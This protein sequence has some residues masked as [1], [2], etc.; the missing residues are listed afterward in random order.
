MFFYNQQPNLYLGYMKTTTKTILLMSLYCLIHQQAAAQ[1]N[2]VPNPSFEDYDSC[3]YFITD[4]YAKYWK[5]PSTATPDYH[6]ANCNNS[7]S[8]VPQN[9]FGYQFARTGFAYAGFLTSDLSP[10][11]TEYRE[12]IQ[13]KL[14]QK[15]ESGK[16]YTISF[17]V[18]FADSSQKACDNIGA[19]ISNNAIS[20]I[21]NL[22]INVIPQIVS[23]HRHPIDNSIEWTE[24]SGTYNAD[25]GEEYLTIGVFSNNSNTSYIETNRGWSE[26]PYYYVDDV[27]IIL[28][29]NFPFMVP[30][31]F[32][33]NADLT[34]DTY[35]P[36]YFDNNLKVKEFRIYNCWGELVYNNPDTPWDG[37]YKGIPQPQGI[38]AFFVYVA[39]PV[40]DN[41]SKIPTYKK[42]GSFALIR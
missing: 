16:R 30:T 31:A 19:Y 9:G 6:Q 3:A 25:G 24:I 11:S 42:V 12:Y 40:P 41:L 4:F 1:I 5:S 33:P 13:C 38:Y 35:Y 22:R 18:S 23:T 7:F 32:T 27:A 20:S 28:D 14:L 17:Y 10:K 34:N 29:E 37:T 26:E 15:L 21:D 36:V 8:G 2:L 39:L